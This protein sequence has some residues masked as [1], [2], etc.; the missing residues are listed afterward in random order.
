MRQ[1]LGGGALPMDLQ[2]RIDEFDNGGF[3]LGEAAAAFAGDSPETRRRLL[4]LVSAV[5]GGSSPP[6]VCLREVPPER[7]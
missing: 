2:F 6:Q 3:D 5:H 4:E 7:I 1:V